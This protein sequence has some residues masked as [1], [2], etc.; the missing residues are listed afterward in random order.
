[1][2]R[3]GR[4]TSTGRTDSG[5]IV[6]G[7]TAEA[8]Y[9]AFADPEALMKWLPP[10]RVKGRVLEYDFREGGAF[11]IALSH[12][13][14]APETGET[15]GRTDVSVG[16]FVILE[17]GRRIVQAVELESADAALQAEMLLTWSFEPT[18]GGTKVTATAQNVPPWISRAD[19]EAGL[20]SSLDN[21]AE[22]LS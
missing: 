18:A 19:H 12:D 16:H 7:A 22:Y 17:P 9:A 2:R 8:V 10:G 14:D 15:S 3:V 21:L 4:S 5:W 1:M 20:R 11:R 13:D 6:V